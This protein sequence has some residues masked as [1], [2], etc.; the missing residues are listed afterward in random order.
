MREKRLDP[1]YKAKEKKQRVEKMST[2]QEKERR[3]D[4]K[5]S[6]SGI[7]ANTR[8]M[9]SFNHKQKQY[10]SYLLRKYGIT[11]NDVDKMTPAQEKR[12]AALNLIEN[13]DDGMKRCSKCHNKK[14]PSEF[15]NLK[16]SRD[17][18]A[19]WCRVC[20]G[21]HAKEWRSANP[22]LAKERS[23]KSMIK[24]NYHIDYEIWISLLKK[25][26]GKCAIC[27]DAF[28]SPSYAH[29]DH[30]HKTNKIR[31]LL[32]MKCNIGIS[33]FKDDPKLINEAIKYLQETNG[34]DCVE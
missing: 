23:R 6:E 3:K 27:K 19:S 15:A 28:K 14:P 31:G 29:T 10:K 13:I 34:E 21:I 1:E 5:M 18:K 7:A 17:G 33:N 20:T 24:K 9:N 32:C 26:D 4:Y 16:P 22:I 11:I 30:D 12:C 25:Q 8:H 2:Q